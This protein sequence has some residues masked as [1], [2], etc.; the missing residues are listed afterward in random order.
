MGSVLEW[1]ID[2]SEQPAGL[3]VV[4][5]QDGA[6]RGSQ[7][8]APDNSDIIHPG[9][10]IQ[11]GILPGQSEGAG[12]RAASGRPAMSGSTGA[13]LPPYTVGLPWWVPDQLWEGDPGASRERR[14]DVQGGMP[15]RCSESIIRRAEWAGKL[16]RRRM[17]DVA[18]VNLVSDL[19]SAALLDPLHGDTAVEEL[20][21]RGERSSV[22][23]DTLQSDLTQLSSRAT[24]GR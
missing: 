24:A 10:G 23:A 7:V 4:A 18:A 22:A 1:P 21:Q 2:E 3:F 16:P 15:H 9:S 8:N 5:V 11:G 20:V 12:R 6:K 17:R 19:V 13:R 14:R